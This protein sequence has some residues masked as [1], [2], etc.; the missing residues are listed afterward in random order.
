[1]SFYNVKKFVCE[2]SGNSN[3]TFFEALKVEHNELFSMQSN[4]PEPVKEPILRHVSFST[5][6]RI[7][8]LVDQVYSKFKDDYFPG[9]K[10]IV[11]YTG[12]YRAHGV[13]KEKV[14]FNSRMDSNGILQRPFIT[15]R[16]Y[17]PADQKEIDIEDASLIYRER[18][19]FTKSYVKTF[20]KMS[21]VR[22]NRLGAPWVIRDE[23]AKKY[24]ISL[25]WPS[26]LKK[27]DTESTA[28]KKTP[29]KISILND[30]DHNSF[31][32]GVA[33]GGDDNPSN[34]S[35]TMTGD[36]KNDTEINYETKN[37]KQLLSKT[38]SNSTKVSED[39]SAENNAQISI[40]NRNENSIDYGMRSTR[41]FS[42]TIFENLKETPP[43]Q[44][45]L[46]QKWCQHWYEILKRTTAY[47]EDMQSEDR[48]RD[49]VLKLFQFIGVKIVDK[50][51]PNNTHF[52]I[53]R[54]QF[55]L[56]EVYQES[57]P[58][59]YVHIKRIKVWHYEKCQRFFKSIKISNRRIY[60]IA[61]QQAI[62]KTNN[63]I[64][65][66]ANIDDSG[67]YKNDSDNNIDNNNEDHNNANDEDA[68]GNKGNKD[69]KN[70][71]FVSIAPAPSNN[72]S[73]NDKTTD[74]SKTKEKGKSRSKGKAKSKAK[75]KSDND[76][77][78]NEEE[79]PKKNSDTDIKSENL[80]SDESENKADTAA[81][82]PSNEKK[83]N[84][85]VIMEDLL[86][87]AK[88][89]MI[90]P[91]WK[92]LAGFEKLPF[93]YETSPI[94]MSNLLEVWI[95]LNMFHEPFVIDTFTFDD[96]IYALQWKDST[97]PCP[98]LLDI[99][100]ALLTCI[101]SKDGELLI[102]L[103]VAV[104]SEIKQKEREIKK[105][106]LMKE[107]EK[108]RKN[109]IKLEKD[110]IKLEDDNENNGG[111]GN[112]NEEEGDNED[113]DD[114]DMDV[115]EEDEEEVEEINHN[116]YSILDY[117]KRS[118][119]ER[120]QKRDFKNG[121][122]LI[123]LLGVFSITEFIP[124]FKKEIVKIYE[125][126]SPIDEIPT[127]ERLMINFYENVNAV[128]R[129][130]ILSILMNLLLNGSI[131]RTQTDY[132]VEKAASLRRE[133]IEIQKD[134]KSKIEAAHIAN[135]DLLESLRAIDVK[136]I[137]QRLDNIEL[138]S[139][140]SET[141]KEKF[142]EN[143]NKGGRPTQNSLP[144]EP[145]PLEKAVAAGHPEFLKLL[146]V[147]SEKIEEVE[148]LKKRKLEIDRTL[149]ELNCQRIRY[150]GRD[151][152]YNRYWWF[153]RN[154]LPNL[155]GNKDDDDDD[156]EN[157]G[158]D[159][160]D[161][162]T[163]TNSD[164]SNGNGI[165]T[166]EVNS[167]NGKDDDDDNDTE[168]NSE[169]YLMGRIWIQGPSDIDILHLKEDA[170][171]GFERKCVEEGDKLLNNERDWV[172][173]DE[174]EDF[175]KLILS[176][177]ERGLRE[178][179]LKKELN[180]SKDRVISSFKARK[181]F[182]GGDEQQLIIVQYIKDLES[183]KSKG[184]LKEGGVGNG[185]SVNKKSKPANEE[186]LAKVGDL[187]EG[188]GDEP[189]GAD[190]DDENDVLVTRSRR[191]LRNKR[192]SEEAD[193]GITTRSKRLQ[194]RSGSHLQR[195]MIVLDDDEDIDQPELS[196]SSDDE[197]E[198]SEDSVLEEMVDNLQLPSESDTLEFRAK[199]IRRAKEKLSHLEAVQRE[200]NMILWVNSS[201]IE[202]QG[203][204]HYDGPKV[205]APPRNPR[206]KRGGRHG[207][208]NRNSK[209]TRGRRGRR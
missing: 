164:K 61:K 70:P 163:E 109:S 14:V 146:N 207:N 188:T 204:T 159:E 202:K 102:T 147:R 151:K 121:S 40:F 86:L 36:L 145:S 5:V 71:N 33:N 174:I 111:D 167:T 37:Q 198:R 154:G 169:T 178:K 203:Y 208:S 1:M 127:P 132:V 75:H 8:L 41:G 84:K 15:Y 22:S 64:E 12:G 126:L 190:E 161:H 139:L 44:D 183:G 53:T 88:P 34:T 91:N 82:E 168:Y 114:E 115:E 13:V 46:Y 118:W 20:L 4:F 148:R 54:R 79:K 175:E 56:K 131:I 9:D 57:D 125:A 166:D 176:L 144:S 149:V 196:D 152:Y 43:T 87:P 90:K 150:L 35:D 110:V 156:D 85:V 30:D 192:S 138:E 171:A 193:I 99:F 11:K 74:K 103:P 73:Q 31:N 50:F 142:I 165:T 26:H 136:E 78:K 6:P 162:S 177:N 173:I 191:S 135:K 108:E 18:N 66:L 180:D 81:K 186:E 45:D 95:F 94:S 97:Q 98:L 123:I 32:Y 17:L 63:G 119:R 100:C 120:L 194:T 23:I 209:T 104:E 195:N 2:T 39:Q 62:N 72:D 24:K 93:D 199:L 69:V 157:D 27:F 189:S 65:S 52:I 201:A 80:K 160:N 76:N 134:L 141:E 38:N 48:A 96:F 68:D 172:Y 124:E 143:R 89:D 200:N 113:D 16:I 29:N 153:E 187:K 60:Q 58:F 55:S 106:K 130:S 133:K 92:V 42:H 67:N 155:G 28:T 129:I 83:V 205:V 21:L 7:D 140:K 116:A 105:K 137:K 158:D 185:D 49:K 101:M 59:Y 197:H 10:V 179:A 184:N 181:K 19:R 122:W 25:D 51:D 182:L 128:G 107:K 3:F 206:N 170:G 47:F 77:D 112:D 117:K